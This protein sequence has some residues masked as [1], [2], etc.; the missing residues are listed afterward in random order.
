MLVAVE[1]DAMAKAMR[2][3]F[4]VGAKAGGG[5]HRASGIVNG[6]R[7]FACAGR[8]KGRALGLSD[9]LVRAFDFVGRLAEDAGARDIRL[10]ALDGAAAIDENNVA[11]PQRLPLA[12][13]VRQRGGS[14]KQNKPIAP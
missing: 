4:I 11:L 8:V 6:T 2:E 13:A 12:C 5:D 14:A 9:Q 10:V 7:K 1:A 3:E